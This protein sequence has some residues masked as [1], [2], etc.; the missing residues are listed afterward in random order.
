[1]STHYM[2]EA[3]N[4]GRL[5]LMNRGKLIALDTPR[6][7]RRGLKDPILELRVTDGPGA[8]EALLEIPGIIEAAMFGRNLHVMV[9]A[10]EPVSTSGPTDR[11]PGAGGASGMADRGP[12]AGGAASGMADRGPGTG[13]AADPG[14]AIRA[15]LS[16]RGIDLLGTRRVDPSLEDVFVAR[17]RAAGGGTV[18]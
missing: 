7:L 3:E 4:C 16:A 10:R 14:P 12:G 15:A 18:D 2:E 1:V 8:V 13:G 11:G 5:A 17:V 6:G 9:S